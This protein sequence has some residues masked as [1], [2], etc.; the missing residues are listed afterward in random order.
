[1]ERD[2][3]DIGLIRRYVRGELS[4]REMYALERRAQDDPLLMDIILGMEREAQEIHEA[5]VTDIRKRIALRTGRGR[6]RQLTPFQRWAVAASVLLAL[7]ISTLWFTRQDMLEQSQPTLATTSTDTGAQFPEQSTTTPKSRVAGETAEAKPT[8]QSTVPAMEDQVAPTSK[9]LAVVPTEE[10]ETADIEPAKALA[11]TAIPAMDSPA[12]DTTPLRTAEAL[13][14]RVS[15]VALRREAA[16]SRMAENVREMAADS[17]VGTVV[18]GETQ[19]P[20]QGLDT[21]ALSEVVVVGYG[22]KSKR[23][24]TSQPEPTNGWRAY[25]RYL[26]QGV[27]SAEDTGTVTLTFTVDDDGS[28]TG[29]QVVHTTHPALVEW[30]IRLVREGP[31]WKPSKNGERNVELQVRF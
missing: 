19:T 5:N 22:K 14:G 30:A 28:P 13:S 17:L 27:K 21:T 31:K 25:N 20:L 16:N 29:I 4:P 26:K 24:T 10:T 1:M 15:G 11:A 23:E 18:D 2:K 3:V 7:T 6:T 8:P 12:R 9:R